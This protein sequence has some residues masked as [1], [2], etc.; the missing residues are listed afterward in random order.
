MRPVHC[1]ALLSVA[2]ALPVL[3]KL[4][5]QSDEAKAA[6]AETAAKAAWADKVGAYKLCLSQD[7]VAESYKKSGKASAPAAVQTAAPA[8]GA[9]PAP[10]TIP[11][12]AD[13]GPYVGGD[14]S[15]FHLAHDVEQAWE[16][17]APF[18]LHE[19]NAYGAWMAS[20]GIG[21]EGGYE[22]TADAD[23]L[24]KTGQYRVLT[25]DDL[26]T[27]IRA[28][29]DFGFTIFHPMAG[30]VPPAMAWESLHLFEREVLPQ[31]GSG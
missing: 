1:A 24:R 18:A 25:P 29:G 19:V 2:L 26:A 6:A 28:K 4:P 7:R 30:G 5:A 9:T 12:C 8:S 3:A 10:V 23:A 14:T 21:A 16:D 15:A 11:G 22:T 27:E 13:P 20:A 17:Y 31:L